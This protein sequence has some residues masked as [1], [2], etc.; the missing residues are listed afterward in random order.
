MVI[1]ERNSWFRRVVEQ[2]KYIQ[3]KIS[4]TNS[5]KNAIHGLH[6]PLWK[7]FLSEKAWK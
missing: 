2:D 4:E 5:S 1:Q 7:T 6:F 3:F